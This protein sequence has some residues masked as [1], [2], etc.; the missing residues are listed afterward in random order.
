V[1]YNIKILEEAGLIEVNEYH[2]SE[3]MK[4]VNHY[5]LANKYVVIAPK[6]DVLGLKDKLKS[7]LPSIG[8]V[9]GSALAYQ[10]IIKVSKMELTES[11]SNLIETEET[12]L[13]SS[14]EAIRNTALTEKSS[15]TI[16]ASAEPYSAVSQLSEQ[17]PE[18]N[19]ALMIIIGC[20]AV[21]AVYLLIDWLRHKKR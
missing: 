18:I 3:K 13:P 1:H 11:A 17:I 21:F 5:S 20:I 16:A 9:G 19:A 4:E 12:L 8:I 2:Y 15:D 6:N 7:I 14:L 10:Y